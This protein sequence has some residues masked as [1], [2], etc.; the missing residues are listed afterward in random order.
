[1]RTKPIFLFA[2]TIKPEEAWDLVHYLRTLAQESGAYPLTDFQRWRRNRR[3]TENHRD[4]D[5]FRHQ[6]VV[7]RK[8]K[9]RRN[10]G[11]RTKHLFLAGV[12]ILAAVATT[13]AAPGGGPVSGEGAYEG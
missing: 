7:S 1:M 5:R 11:M 13:S 10:K 2:C 12:A 9:F 8:T 6:A 4:H 3:C